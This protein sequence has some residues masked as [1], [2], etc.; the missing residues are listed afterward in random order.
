MLDRNTKKSAAEM[1]GANIG[2]RNVLLG[3]VGMAAVAVGRPAAAR[4]LQHCG[5]PHGRHVYLD[6]TDEEWRAILSNEEYRILR[7]GGT[8]RIFASDFARENLVDIYHCRGCSAELY[9]GEDYV[10]KDI[11][12][13]FFAHSFPDAVLTG[14]D[15]TDLNGVFKEP[16]RMMEVH[17]R[18]CGSHLGH[19]VSIGGKVLHCINGT[20]LSAAP[21]IY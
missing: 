15:E 5:G 11:G 10:P 19:L 18:C 3:S 20:S 13:V 8:E 6:R 9:S 17:C 12:F 1:D 16:K 2:R 7:E 21:S 14:I 4:D